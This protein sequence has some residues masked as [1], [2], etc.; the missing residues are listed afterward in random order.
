MAVFT[1]KSRPSVAPKYTVLSIATGDDS[2]FADVCSCQSS[3]PVSRSSALRLPLF[4]EMIRRCPAIAGVE[5]FAPR[6]FLDQRSFP[7]RASNAAVR[8]RNVFT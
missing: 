4:E 8:P 7:V 2:I 3:S 6:C 1:A 5:C